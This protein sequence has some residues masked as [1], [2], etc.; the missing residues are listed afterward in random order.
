[1]QNTSSLVNNIQQHHTRQDLGDAILSALIAAGKDLNNL[2]PEDLT[3]V[4][5]FHIR[6]L[7]ATIELA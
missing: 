2:K 7:E 3:P 4:D 5:E 6:G 1:M